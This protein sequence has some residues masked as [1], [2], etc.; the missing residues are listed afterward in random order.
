VVVARN[1]YVA[2]NKADREEALQRHRKV[3]QR[4]LAV[5]RDPRRPGGSHIVFYDHAGADTE[6]SMLYGTSDEIAEKI[7]SLRRV[8][9]KYVILNIGGMSRQSL[10]SFATEIMPAFSGD[11][12]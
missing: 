9:I 3:Q 1:L 5:S 11:P 10:R 8:G 7:S 6:K 12:G 2:K 4:I